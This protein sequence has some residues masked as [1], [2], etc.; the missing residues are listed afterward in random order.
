V[1]IVNDVSRTQPPSPS[2]AE[3]GL[4]LRWKI[5]LLTGISMLLLSALLLAVFAS[6]A[7]RVIHDELR[8][9]ARLT[10]AGLAKSLAY[11]T[12]TGDVISLQVAADGLVRDAPDLVYVFFRGPDG[13]VLAMA[14]AAAVSALDPLALPSARLQ[15]DGLPAPEREVEAGGLRVLDVAVPIVHQESRGEPIGVVQLGVRTD[16]LASQISAITRRAVLLAILVLAVCG[17]AGYVLTWRLASPLERLAAAAAAIAGG[18]LGHDVRVS[19]RDEVGR[20]AASFQTMA[21]GLRGMV[22]DLGSVAS[23]LEGEG[24]LILESVA[25]QASMAAQQAA[26]INETSTTAA[27]IAQTS[28]QATEHADR[29]IEVA[30]KSEDLSVDGKRVVEDAVAAMLSLGDQVKATAAVMS[31][32]SRKSEQIGDVVAT[33]RDVAEQTNVLALNAAIE[34]SRAGEHGK[35]FSVVALEMRNLAEQSKGAAAQVKAMLA[36]L[37]KGA[38]EALRAAGEGE[39]RAQGAIELARTAGAAIEGLAETI[40][41]SSLAARQIANNT[42]QQT[43]GVEQIVTAINQVSSAM[44]D[45]VEGSRRI[46]KGTGNLNALS[47]RLMQAVTRYR[48]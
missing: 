33:V 35:G 15:A 32:L 48:V 41:E 5:L 24:H 14:R 22:A 13:K 43:V 47:K 18:D 20:L 10:A 9:R 1:T 11:P 2:G 34:A 19:G 45:A 3:R 25:Q 29:V 40:R 39:K 4:S 36:E 12:S 27:E 31:E 42:R 6:Q 30:Q 37:D 23:Q 21:E 46:E 38:H 28:K 26:A 8:D 44:S 16:R 17:I 7:R